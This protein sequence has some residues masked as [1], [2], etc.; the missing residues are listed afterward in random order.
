MAYTLPLNDARTKLVYVAGIDGKNGANGRHS[1]TN[2]GLVL[3][4]TYRELL[5]RAGQLGLPHGLTTTTGTLGAAE[6]GEDFVSLDIPNGAAEVIGVD[7]RCGAKPEKLD[8]ITWEQRR[9][10]CFLEPPHGIGFWATRE[11]PSVSGS[12]L[13]AG[14][15]AIW[16]TRLAGLSYTL[17]QVRQWV[18][19]TS[20]TD[21]FMLHEGW[22]SWLLNKAAMAVAQ[23]DTNT[24]G[25]F[26]TARDAWLTADALLEA[27][28]GRFNRAGGG[29][30]TPY[31]RVSL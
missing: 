25:S 18:E 10:V 4:W 21:V 2:L 30:P 3:N 11:G 26:D 29:E 15:L 1:P 19:I 13:T 12:T 24:R 28:A 7:V 20:G 9:D 22:E 14:K 27:Q 16:P 8:P 17:S 6:T 23:R 5:S 31:C